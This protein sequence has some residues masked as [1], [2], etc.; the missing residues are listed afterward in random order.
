MR[1]PLRTNPSLALLLFQLL[2]TLCNPKAIDVLQSQTQLEEH[3]LNFC[4]MT[5]LAAENG[6]QKTSMGQFM[7][8]SCSPEFYHCRWQS[9]GFHTYKK[10]C[11]I[12]P[13]PALG[14]VQTTPIS[15]SGSGSRLGAGAA[16]SQSQLPAPEPW[17]SL[18]LVFDTLG[19]QNCNYD[20]N[21]KTCGLQ[22]APEACTN[23]TDFACPLSET[24]V[25]LGQR[26]DGAYDCI[27]EEDEQNCPMCKAEEFPCVK[28]EQCIPMTGRCNGIKECRD[29]TDEMDCEECPAGNFLCRKSNK[30]IPAIQR[31]DGTS[32]CPQG[33]DELLCKKDASQ[34]YVCENRKDQVAR[35]LVCD[36]KEDCPDGSDE[37]YCLRPSLPVAPEK[38]VEA[39]ELT[40]TAIYAPQ[41]LPISPI[42]AST[43]A[44]VSIMPL[45]SVDSLRIAGNR[46]VGKATASFPRVQF[47]ESKAIDA[48]T[49]ATS[50]MQSQEVTEAGDAEDSLHSKPTVQM[51][52]Y[53]LPN[54]KLTRGDCNEPC[55]QDEEI[56]VFVG[57]KGRKTFTPTTWS[58]RQEAATAPQIA[59]TQPNQTHDPLQA[60]SDKYGADRNELLRKIE[61]ILKNESEPTAR[62]SKTNAEPFH[63]LSKTITVTGRPHKWQPSL[64]TNSQRPTTPLPYHR[65]RAPFPDGAAAAASPCPHV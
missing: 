16:Q 39:N 1:S 41:S 12:A 20:Y 10:N 7:G 43:P 30:C 17:Q 61:R 54:E 63:R 60:L 8:Y 46:Q 53:R 34:M 11:R 27:L 59:V 51:K 37:K 49:E 21:V 31:C 32:D 18:G 25:P 22:S 55:A 40:S 64:S 42:A 47:G 45:P 65:R 9:D 36:G 29:G 62:T 44:P 38:S 26:C 14:S 35:N 33:E 23:A 52:K 48:S 15:G 2:R 58:Y 5:E 56:P 3:P 57:Q 24:C 4:N 50:P 6:L 19:T 13:A 28:S